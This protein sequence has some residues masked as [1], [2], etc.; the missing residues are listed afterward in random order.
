MEQA[1]LNIGYLAYNTTVAP[2]D[3]PEVRHALN[4]AMD[5]EAM[6]EAYPAMPHAYWKERHV[7]LLTRTFPEGQVIITIDGEL[8]GGALSIIVD[9]ARYEPGHTY[10]EISG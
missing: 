7:E 5:K 10:R 6:I 3:K 1:G 8:A 2:F 9:Y 4:M